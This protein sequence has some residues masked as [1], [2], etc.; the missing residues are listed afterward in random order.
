M[1][2]GQGADLVE[3]YRRWLSTSPEL[4]PLAR[5]RIEAKLAF[6]ETGSP[7]A[8][9]AR[10]GPMDESD[11]EATVTLQTLLMLGELDRYFDQWQADIEQG[12]TQLWITRS[13]YIPGGKPVVEHPRFLD[14][15]EKLGLIPVWEELGYPM[16]CERVQDDRGDHLAC[17]NW[18]K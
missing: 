17:P 15:V 12:G 7:D 10:F 11:P 16:G 14:I 5:K 1:S 13:I 3:M 4:T 8:F 6:Y 18:P 9:W 2:R